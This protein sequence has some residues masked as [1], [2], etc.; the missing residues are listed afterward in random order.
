MTQMTFLVTLSLV[1]AGKVNFKDIALTAGTY[2]I[3]FFAIAPRSVTFPG[4]VMLKLLLVGIY[5]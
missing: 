5:T 1:Y 2:I 3:F 4:P